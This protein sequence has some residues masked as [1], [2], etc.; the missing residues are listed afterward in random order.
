VLVAIG[1]AQLYEHVPAAGAAALVLLLLGAVYMLQLVASGARSGRSA[2]GV[3]EQRVVE[4]L[5]CALRERDPE[6]ARHAAGVARFS[7]SIAEAA[8]L[9]EDQLRAAH[10]AGLLHDLG[11]LSLSDVA[12][13]SAGSLSEH[14][15]AAIRR[16]PEVGA[17]MARSLGLSEP[18]VEA[19]AA[20]HER[21]DGRGYPRGLAGEAIPVLARVVAV[22]E[23]YDTL[24]AAAYRPRVS[25]FQALSELRRVAGTQLDGRYVEALAA[26]IAHRPAAERLADAADVDVE[27]ALHRAVADPA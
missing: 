5:L 27:L 19:I 23:V 20:H 15:W 7:R 3:D 1:V 24:T 25:S 21:P 9:P 12:L 4:E 14:E 10:V 13:G 16:H 6:S 22:A 2:V 26:V 18:V 11:R 8:G 17:A